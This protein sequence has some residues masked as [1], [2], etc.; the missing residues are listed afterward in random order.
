MNREDLS[1]RKVTLARCV[2]KCVCV[3]VCVYEKGLLRNSSLVQ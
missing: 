3:C 2:F 1:V